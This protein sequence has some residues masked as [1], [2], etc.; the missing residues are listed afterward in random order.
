VVVVADHPG[1]VAVAEEV[2]LAPVAAVEPHR[3][4]AVQ[5]VHRDRHVV[6]VLDHDHEVV[7]RVHQ[8]PDDHRPAKAPRHLAELPHEPPPVGV[9]DEDR[10][11]VDAVDGD[12][13]QPSLEVMSDNARHGFR[14]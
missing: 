11:L 6:D 1:R 3:V 4:Q 13:K 14:R 10:S 12:V 7:V 2:A 9:L 8:A 5:P